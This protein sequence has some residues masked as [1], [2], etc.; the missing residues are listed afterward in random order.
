MVMERDWSWAEAETAHRVEIK[1]RMTVIC[2]RRLGETLMDTSWGRGVIETQAPLPLET[3]RGVG[4]LLV[5]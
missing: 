3:T 4:R 1:K 5:S 2:E